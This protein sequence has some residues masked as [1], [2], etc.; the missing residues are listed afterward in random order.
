[1]DLSQFSLEGKVALIT[2]GS[3]GIGEATAL[4]F[5]KA[6]AD[7][8]VTSRTLPDLERVAEAVKDLGR[9][10]LAVT[11]DIGQ[12]DQI[13]GLVEK[14]VDG[15][16]RIDILVNN[17]GT[18][19]FSTAIDVDESTWETVMNLDLKG[20]FFLSQA[21]ARVMRD[22]SGGSIINIASASGYKPSVQ[23][24]VYAIAKAGVLMATK[25]M[26]Q[27]WHAYNV[28]VN[29]IAPGAIN[30]ELLSKIWAD[31]PEKHVE[32]VKKAI[33]ETIIQGRIGEPREI[34]DA[35]IFMASNAASFITGQ[36]LV[37]DGGY[38]V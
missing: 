12:M 13:T 21:V 17:A 29:G 23:S 16:G 4:G 11:A 26:A 19:D 37:V 3:Q 15:F 14:V 27:Q 24:C 22:H 36:T 8:A 35:V 9:R 20:L 30:T 5:A 34:A 33:A 7:V 32:P 2:G 38:L 6:G 10:S 1:M 31:L 25:T 28:R 18:G